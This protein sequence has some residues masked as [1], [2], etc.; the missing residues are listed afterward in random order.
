MQLLTEEIM[1]TAE[2]EING[3]PR[4]R[5]L[6]GY[7][8]AGLVALYAIYRTDL[9]SRVGSMSGSLWFPGMKEH[10]FSHE[11]KRCPDCMCFS[12]GTR[13]AKLETRFWE[14]SNRTQ[15][16]F[17]LSTEARKSTQCFSWTLGT[18]TIIL[19]SAQLQTFV[20]FWVGEATPPL[21]RQY[22]LYRRFENWYAWL[23]KIP[24][25]SVPTE[26]QY[27]KPEYK[28]EP[29][30]TGDGRCAAPGQEGLFD[31][32]FDHRQRRST[33]KQWN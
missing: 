12:L 19:W 2:K 13:R 1:P 5:G 22:F 8:L 10:I 28:K 31:H 29:F 23:E 33:R 3:V 21:A 9:F 17:M 26:V 4:W 18:I 20:S 25:F 15:R 6:A 27:P 24:C 16:R 32:M 7:S 14:V 30:W 11:P